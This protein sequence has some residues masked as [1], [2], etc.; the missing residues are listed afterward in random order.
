VIALYGHGMHEFVL[1]ELEIGTRAARYEDSERCG[2]SAL[3]DLHYAEWVRLHQHPEPAH[4]W[5]AWRA[6]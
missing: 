6:R 1:R 4:S 3:D 2:W 5:R